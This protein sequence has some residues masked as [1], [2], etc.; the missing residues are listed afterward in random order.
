MFDYRIVDDLDMNRFIFQV[1]DW[2]N[3][4]N[5]CLGHRLDR[6]YEFELCPLYHYRSDLHPFAKIGKCNM[7]LCMRKPQKIRHEIKTN[8]LYID[9]VTTSLPMFS[10]YS[11]HSWC[12]VTP[13]C[14][15]LTLLLIGSHRVFPVHVLL[16]FSVWSLDSHG[17]AREFQ[18]LYSYLYW[19][20]LSSPT[21][22]INFNWDLRSRNHK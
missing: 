1:H 11:R 4:S 9:N 17:S 15:T 5:R 6:E 20:R 13:L 12:N 16:L 7:P 21:S 14:P 3:M 8:D 18:R 19:I 10:F 22:S 2:E